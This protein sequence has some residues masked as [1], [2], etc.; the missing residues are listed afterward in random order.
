MVAMFRMDLERMWKS[1]SPYICLA[2][3]ILFFYFAG[4]MLL[5]AIRPELRQAALDMGM[6]ITKS[7]ELD[8][9]F[10][11][12]QPRIE[13][14]HSMILGGGGMYIFLCGIMVLFV[15]SDFESGFAKNIF[16][17]ESKRWKYIFSKMALMQIIG[18]VYFIVLVFSSFLFSKMTKM[19]FASSSWMDYLR[20][21]IVL[22][23]M[24][25]GFCAQS[26]VVLMITRS[27]A[28]GIAVAI[29]L[30]GGIVTAIIEAICNLF[31]FSI[32]KWTLYGSIKNI[33][34]PLTLS[35]IAFPIT[36]GIGWTILWLAIS[37][38]LIQ[39]KDVA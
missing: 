1:K 13:V 11:A 38:V 16:S 35:Q 22:C 37:I 12:D 27:K 6:E 17:L 20:Y 36:V 34:F 26:M 33:T 23:A 7:D 21:M 25:G 14:L 30:P 29:L 8:F 32:L 39:K 9:S 15:C 4:I 3:L 31:D 2:F 18:I 5:V 28:A 10:L 24:N 19:E